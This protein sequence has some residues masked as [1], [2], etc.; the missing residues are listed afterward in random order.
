MKKLSIF[1]TAVLVMT[2]LALQVSAFEEVGGRPARHPQVEVWL[3]KHNGSVYRPGQYV[4]VYFQ[5]DEDCY[6]AVYNVDAEGFV[7]VLYP[8]YK[9]QAWVESGRIY[10]IPDPY[11]D[12][13]LVVDGPKGIEYVVAVVSEFPLNLRAI[14]DIE[15]G[16]EEVNYWPLGRVTGDPHLAIQEINER[17]AWGD[18]EYEPE[19]YASDASWFYVNQ[20]VPYPRYI[21]YHWYPEYIYDPW[22]DPYDDVHIWIDF[23]WDHHW[24]RPWWWCRG[25]QPIYVYWYIDRDTG[26]RVT[27]KGEYHTDRRQPDWYR[28]KP[29]RHDGGGDRPS[30]YDDTD[31]GNWENRRR[32]PWGE[33]GPDMDVIR[34]RAVGREQV[35]L[36]RKTQR[37]SREQE[38]GGA[39][40]EVRSREASDRTSPDQNR[41]PRSRSEIRPSESS[42]TPREQ[43]SVQTR[44]TRTSETKKVTKSSSRRSTFGKIVGNVTKIF[45]GDS[46]KEKS[47]SSQGSRSSDSKKS[48][49]ESS[50]SSDRNSKSNS[51]S[52][53]KTR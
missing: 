48:R 11:D 13:D 22:W 26:R 40:T 43:K 12:Y 53:K 20:W 14:Y 31:P 36:E 17:L 44:S 7:H 19:G 41:S 18:E 1:L 21:V 10:E 45:T 24:C 39:K 38:D 3:N 8:K 28:E 42:R 32:S 47:S 37:S 25:C 6:A 2:A 9:D 35:D 30:R 50:S 15:D 4:R 49:S 27:W 29:T 52:E 34:E 23:Y 16:L 46:K 5:V 33:P 51:E